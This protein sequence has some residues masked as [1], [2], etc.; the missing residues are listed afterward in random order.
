MIATVVKLTFLIF[1]KYCLNSKSTYCLMVAMDFFQFVFCFMP[2]SEQF[3]FKKKLFVFQSV[4]KS[5]EHTCMK[6]MSNEMPL[7]MVKI[8]REYFF[9]NIFRCAKMHFALLI[10]QGT[11]AFPAHTETS[12]VTPA[13]F[14]FDTERDCYMNAFNRNELFFIP[15]YGTLLTL[16]CVS[17]AFQSVRKIL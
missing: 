14:L 3:Y 13:Q 16:S 6:Y 9:Y 15:K 4:L 8:L 5:K 7:K 1:H 2:Y 10:L 12:D 17:N 11:V